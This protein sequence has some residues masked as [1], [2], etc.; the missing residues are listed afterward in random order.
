[1][2][3]PRPPCIVRRSRRKPHSAAELY[4]AA[5][6]LGIGGEHEFEAVGP[7]RRLRETADVIQFAFLL[8]PVAIYRVLAAQFNSFTSGTRSGPSRRER[9]QVRS[10]VGRVVLDS[11]S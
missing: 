3:P 8:A 5:A 7:A 1:M 10:E 4:K 2:A 9:R 11:R 6:A